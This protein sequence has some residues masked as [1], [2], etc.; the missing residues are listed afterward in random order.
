MSERVAV[1]LEEPKIAIVE[2]PGE[3]DDFGSRRLATTL[4]SLLAEGRH[5]A[6]DLRATTFVDSTTAASLIEACRTA[7][8][9]GL[10]LV[11]ALDD[12]AWPVRRLFELARLDQVLPVVP[13]LEDALARIRA[14]WR[15]RER[16]SLAERRCGRDRR[17]GASRYEGPE[18]RSGRERRSGV[19]R[20][21]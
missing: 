12:A 10:G 5:V 4:A 18:R 1:R 7:S 17:V 16:R 21:H 11:I 15:G 9:L 20:R 6:V 3:Y 2:L 13:R 8:E 19:D 14:G